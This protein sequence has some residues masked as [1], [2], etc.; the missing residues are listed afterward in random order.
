MNIIFDF[1][2]V[3]VDWNP[4]YVYLP[5][6]QSANQMQ[7]FYQDTQIHHHN[8]ALDRGVPYDQLLKS[9]AEQYPHY[10]EAIYLWKTCWHKMISGPIAGSVAILKSLHQEGYTV[11]GLTNW[12]AE[13]FPYVYYTY[14]FFHLFKDIVVSGRENTIKP[15][16]EIYQLLLSR[17]QL[18]P[19]TCL[20]IDD[21]CDNI[22]AAQ[23]L[24]IKTI[25]FKSPQQLLAALKA[26]GVAINPA[27]NLD[28]PA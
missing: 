9:L 19:H 27:I 23:A 22:V 16:P 21:N 6:F 18:Q 17:N 5:Y 1:G 13:T 4:D 2:A 10:K 26:L 11:Y 15:E 24:G 12:A 7:Q 28:L 8:K 25:H 20:F 3:L 14:D